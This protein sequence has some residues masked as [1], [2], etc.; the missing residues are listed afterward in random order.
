MA[1]PPQEQLKAHV[2][3]RSKSAQS[4]VGQL[5]PGSEPRSEIPELT[6]LTA[7]VVSLAN[8]T[9][10]KALLLLESAMVE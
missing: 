1:N 9:R 2:V 6:E 7:A 10:S 3:P 5:L 4:T 8:G